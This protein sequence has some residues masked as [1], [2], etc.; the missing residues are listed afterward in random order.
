[1]MTT[2][3][4]SARAPKFDPRRNIVPDRLDLRDRPYMPELRT[5]PAIEM[6]RLARL[7]VL[8]Q[9]A[10]SACTGFALASVVNFLLRKHRDPHSPPMSPFMLYSMARRYDEFPGSAED[11][12]SSLRGAMKGWYK[13]GVCRLDLWPTPDMPPPAATPREDWWLDAAL[14]PLG[15]YYRVDT[16]SVTDM[17]VALHDVG[18]LYAS[19]VCH[20]GWLKGGHGGGKRIWTIPREEV[21]PDDGG[22]AFVIVGYTA[23]GFIVQNSWGARWGTRGL[24]ILTYQ[25]WTENAM[26]CWVAQVGVATQQH[27]EIARSPSLRLDKGRVQIAADNTLRDREISPFVIDMENNGRPLELANVKAWMA[28][29]PASESTTH[30]G[31]DDDP[32]TM[33]SVINLIKGRRV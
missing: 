4:P 27:L 3:R 5:P 8:D 23:A 13:H 20:G 2:A 32:V 26:D 1:M 11:S 25:D 28:P 14:R 30:G 15:A 6:T 17:H 18:I 31:F 22:H 10:T 7:P 29:G 16:R 12:G 21:H 19:V 9:Q 24:A 33:K